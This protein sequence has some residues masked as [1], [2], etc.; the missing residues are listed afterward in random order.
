M[1]KLIF[2]IRQTNNPENPEGDYYPFFVEI[3]GELV[4][5]RAP[6][7]LID[8]IPCMS[9][10]TPYQEMADYEEKNIVIFQFLTKGYPGKTS[11]SA[12][13]AYVCEI[14][15]RNKKLILKYNNELGKLIPSFSI[16]RILE[17]Q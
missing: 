12:Y 5:Q 1:E 8:I 11:L 14:H 2:K 7:E 9:R 15:Y 10:L 16:I 4:R 6:T 17:P 3:D 13:D